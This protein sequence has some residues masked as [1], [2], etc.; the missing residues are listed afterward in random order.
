MF[1]QAREATMVQYALF[2]QL[3]DKNYVA[4]S[5]VSAVLAIHDLLNP[6][7]LGILAPSLA[8]GV[9]ASA[10]LL[11]LN[12]PITP[13]WKQFG[14]SILIPSPA[15]V[16]PLYNHHNVHSHPNSSLM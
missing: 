14:I 4:G 2:I 1:H 3:R 11:V 10:T 9:V 5:Y 13:A 7:C 8:F 6:H 12:A 16:T 15:L